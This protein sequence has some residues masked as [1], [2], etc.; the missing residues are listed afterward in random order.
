MKK[1]VVR[2]VTVVLLGG[3]VWGTLF[4]S[5]LAQQLKVGYVDVLRLKKEYKEFQEAEAKFEKEMAVWQAKADSMQSEMNDL[6]K[7]V[8]NPPI[9]MREE[10]IS[11]LR[12]ELL[13]KQ[14]EYQIFVDEVMGPD[15]EAAKKE[16]EL[17]KPL[18]EKIN[19]VIKLIALK[20][21]YTY[22]LDSTAGSVL[23]ADEK[24]DLT[25]KVLA[26]LNK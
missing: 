13:V 15:G 26:E 19:T 20:G 7:K 21:N 22:V 12:E 1:A 3:L 10:A 5:S 25:D 8:Q 23:Y 16:Y 9:T 11:K 4:S 17:S 14:N 6:L 18:I 2:A 24:Y